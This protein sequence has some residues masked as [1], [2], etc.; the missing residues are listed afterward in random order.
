M[1]VE[2]TRSV[3]VEAAVTMAGLLGIAGAPIKFVRWFS[4]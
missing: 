1:R 4:F 3:K 2:V